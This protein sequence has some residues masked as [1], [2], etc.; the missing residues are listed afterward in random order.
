MKEVQVVVF[1]KQPVISNKVIQMI[2]TDVSEMFSSFK[3]NIECFNSF[4][5]IKKALVKKTCDGKLMLAILDVQLK[6]EQN[7][8]GIDLAKIIRNLKLNS[9]IIFHTSIDN[10]FQVLNIF[11]NIKPEGYLV[12]S[13]IDYNQLKEAIFKTLSGETYYS[14]SVKLHLREAKL[15]KND[16]DHLDYQILFELSKG[17]KTNKLPSILKT[18]LSTIESR[19][20][21]IAFVLGLNK[22]SS[23]RLVE[24][25]KKRKLV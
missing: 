1:D 19:K 13:E 22:V 21:K 14:D 23:E 3:F 25:A 20:R 6:G 2:L 18:S 10:R 8:T 12:K 5:L 15:R 24:I 4:Y 9:K 16:F 17:V 7:K 11:E